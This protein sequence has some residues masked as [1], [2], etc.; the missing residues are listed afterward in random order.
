MSDRTPL[1][2][3]FRYWLPMFGTW[4]IMAVE[5]P[6]VAAVIARMD[7]PKYNLAAFGVA[8][9]VAILEE[10]EAYAREQSEAS[11]KLDPP[12]FASGLELALVWVAALFTVFHFQ[13]QDG[14]VTERF[15][16]SSQG[17]FEAGEWW[18]PFTSLFLHGD[19]EHLI[20][21]VVFGMLFCIFVA[22]SVGPWFGWALI[23]SSGAIGNFLTAWFYHPEPF[24]SVGASTATFGALG[25]LLSFLVHEVE[26]H[27]RRPAE[28]IFVGFVVFEALFFMAAFVL[29][30]GGFGT[31]DEMFET[32]T[33]IQTGKIRNFPLVLMGSDYWDELLDFMA[34]RRRIAPKS[35]KPIKPEMVCCWPKRWVCPWSGISGQTTWSWAGRAR[36]WL[37]FIISHWPENWGRPNR[38]YS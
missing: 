33:L 5:A 18:R 21:N 14:G 29:M 2:R 37:R 16:N 13:M 23:L 22:Q 19:F 31:M 24:Q 7:E 34:K 17:L 26:L 35:A 30:P 15:C 1:R 4:M 10:F 9:A 38:W 28:V 32:A 11:A 25:M 27:A 36:R 8:Y 12:I 3:I 20:G 6:F